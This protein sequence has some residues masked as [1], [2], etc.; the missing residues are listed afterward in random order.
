MFVKV[1][2]NDSFCEKK[3]DMTNEQWEKLAQFFEVEQM[4]TQTR[5]EY[6]EESFLGMVQLACILIILA[7]LR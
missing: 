1:I 2:D 7:F 3:M 6:N 4:R 5:Y